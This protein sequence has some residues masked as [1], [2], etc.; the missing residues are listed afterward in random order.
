VA[1][2]ASFR[3]GEGP[4]AS[5][6]SLHL[7]NAMKLLIGVGVLV[8]I[9][10]LVPDVAPAML[11]LVALYLVLARPDVVTALLGQSTSALDDLYRRR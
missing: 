3:P 7:P 5:A 11:L 8:A 4:S 1:G 10:E 2:L 9:N 6:P